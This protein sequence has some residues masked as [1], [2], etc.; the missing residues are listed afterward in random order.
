MKQW[1]CYKTVFV[2]EEHGKSTDVSKN[3]D[4]NKSLL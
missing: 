2:V 4:E 1:T 3:A